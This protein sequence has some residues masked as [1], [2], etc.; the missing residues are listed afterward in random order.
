MFTEFKTEANKCNLNSNTAA[1][2]NFV[3]G[4][5]GANNIT[6]KIYEKDPQTLLEVI[7]LVEKFNM[8]QQVTATLTSP[9]L[10]M[11]S[12]DDRCFVCG[13]TG[14]TGH[15][16]PDVQYYN[17]EDFVHFAED[18]QEK[19]PPSGRNTTSP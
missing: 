1:I 6:E 5:W 3:K 18:C 9:T 4:L 15:H 8:A 10:N 13:K 7:K 19:I 12:N 17:R 11:M 14:H 2:C 16:C